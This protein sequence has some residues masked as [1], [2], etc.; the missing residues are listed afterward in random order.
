MGRW[1]PVESLEHTD[2]PVFISDEDGRVDYCNSATADL[3]KR[4]RREIE[5][6]RCYEVMRLR[7]LDGKPLCR[8][9]CAVQAQARRGKL[10]KTRPALFCR[11]GDPPIAVDLVT[12]AVSPANGRRIAILHMLKTSSNGRTA[13]PAE[14]GGYQEAAACA[15]LSPRE[16]QVLRHLSDGAGTDQIAAELFL[17]RATVRNHVRSILSKMKVHSRL[18]AVVA[19]TRRR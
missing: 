6:Q 13:L 14:T 17:S 1:I 8:A 5:G 19:S 12:I 16:R 18:E 4:D 7:S 15:C 10:K 2:Q 9:Q 11:N 3:L